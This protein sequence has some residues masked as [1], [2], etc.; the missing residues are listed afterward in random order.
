MSYADVYI[1]EA[2][3]VYVA[4]LRDPWKFWDA[5]LTEMGK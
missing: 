3:K 1:R 2:A 4:I 5:V